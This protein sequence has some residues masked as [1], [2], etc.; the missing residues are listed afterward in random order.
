MS[1]LSMTAL[2]AIDVANSELIQRNAERLKQAKEA[3]GTKYLLHPANAMSK[4]KF[5]KIA[6]VTS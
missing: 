1:R 4:E 5:R 3:M 6:K 2:K